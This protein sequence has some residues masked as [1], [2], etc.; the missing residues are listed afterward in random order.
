VER[1]VVQDAPSSTETEI[2][3]DLPAVPSLKP[4]ATTRSPSAATPVYD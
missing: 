3:R 4:A 2:K 1:L